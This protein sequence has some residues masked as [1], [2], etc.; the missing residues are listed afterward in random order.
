[1]KSLTIGE[2]FNINVIDLLCDIQ[3]NAVKVTKWKRRNS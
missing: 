1:M 3:Y 2:N